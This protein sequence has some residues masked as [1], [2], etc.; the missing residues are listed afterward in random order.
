[1]VSIAN[2]V[3]LVGDWFNGVQIIEASSLVEAIKRYL[4]HPDVVLAQNK[5]SADAFGIEVSDIVR[6]TAMSHEDRV[7]QSEALAGVDGVKF[8]KKA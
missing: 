3:F 6:E 7:G 4:A 2:K 5:S 8:F 1:M